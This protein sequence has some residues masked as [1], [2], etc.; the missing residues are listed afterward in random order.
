M[1]NIVAALIEAVM[2]GGVATVA[3][4]EVSFHT[5]FSSYH[6]ML[7]RTNHADSDQS[8]FQPF[9]SGC[10]REQILEF[11]FLLSFWWIVY[12]E[13]FNDF[14]WFLYDFSASMLCGFW[15]FFHEYFFLL[16][17]QLKHDQEYF[18]VFQLK[19]S[20]SSNIWPLSLIRG[21]ITFVAFSY[22]C[23]I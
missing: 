11:F 8:S 15:V 20:I 21:L 12:T 5:F 23:K 10:G 1:K 19:F 16:K 14:S 22:K 4:P 9:D 17:L 3:E 6:L 13:I 7:Q 18:S 2:G